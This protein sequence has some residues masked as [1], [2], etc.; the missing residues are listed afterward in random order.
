MGS[1]L[2][3]LL[4]TYARLPVPS[5]REQVM[6]ARAVR[7]WLDWKPS[8]ADLA[9]GI[10]EAPLRLQRVGRRA[11]DQLVSRNMLLVANQARRFSVN[12]VTSLDV[13]D[14]IQEGAL[15]LTRAVELFDPTLGYAFSTYAVWW[16]RQSMTKLLHTSGSIR[17]P[18]KRGSKM[19][20]LRR[21][22]DDFFSQNGRF[23]TDAE[24]M[25]AQNL[26]A[27]DLESLRLA[28]RA[29]HIVSL[30]ASIGSGDD[31]E[32]WGSTVASPAAPA[33]DPAA[34]AA[35]DALG[36]WPQ[37]QQVLARLLVGETMPEISA[38]M[39]ISLPAANRLAKLATKRARWLVGERET[40]TPEG[41][42]CLRFP[43]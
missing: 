38:A 32:T 1:S 30:D 36:P 19:H 26:T 18:V 31:C 28:A 20:Q 40:S 22:Q 37:L 23:P 8:E 11:R 9:E 27:G 2:D 29:R 7:A 17:V 14:L 21:W 16:I 12:S 4:T 39:G 34:V 43:P 25:E 15:G 13:D 24:T 35:V 41:Q 42:M 33:A 3:L 6:L 10:T 5:R